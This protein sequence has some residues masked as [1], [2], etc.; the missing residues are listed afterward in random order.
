MTPTWKNCIFLLTSKNSSWTTSRPLKGREWWT[1]RWNRPTTPC[2]CPCCGSRRSDRVSTGKTAWS[3]WRAGRSRGRG[4]GSGC[5]G[6]NGTR[7]GR[8][9]GDL[10]FWAPTGGA[11][12]SPPAASDTP[13]LV[14][15]P[16]WTASAR[17]TNRGNYEASCIQAQRVRVDV[18]WSHQWKFLVYLLQHLPLTQH[19][20]ILPPGLSLLQLVAGEV[21]KYRTQTWHEKR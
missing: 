7:T 4:R 6:G 10:C 21:G 13:A 15:A 8:L 3:S 5:C 20:L 9:S 2:Y 16:T 11:G 14:P 19:Q 12:R 1:R 18:I 17:E